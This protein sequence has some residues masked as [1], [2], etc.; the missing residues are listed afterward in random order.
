M[1]TVKE[2]MK[3]NPSVKEV[4]VFQINQI[5]EDWLPNSKIRLILQ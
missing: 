4:L 2:L 3:S 1:K 5:E